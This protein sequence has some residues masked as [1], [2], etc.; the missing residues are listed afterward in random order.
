MRRQPRLHGGGET[1]PVDR[2]RPA[3]RHGARARRRTISESSRASSSLSK[4]DRVFERGAAQR[5]AAD[6][7]RQRAG[8]VRRARSCGRISNEVELDAA[9]ARPATPLRSRRDRRR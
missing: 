2:Q 6:E 7:F 9:P 8:M 5:I 1:I 3:G 4:P